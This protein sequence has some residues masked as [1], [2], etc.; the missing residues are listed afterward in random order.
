MKVIFLLFLFYI[1]SNA[2]IIEIYEC[3]QEE[4]TTEEEYTII[5]I[6]SDLRTVVVDDYSYC[7]ILRDAYNV[8]L[9]GILLIILIIGVSS[10]VNYY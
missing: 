9:E 7:I 2:A 8:I 10:I 5:Q 4:I 1:L 3:P 6:K